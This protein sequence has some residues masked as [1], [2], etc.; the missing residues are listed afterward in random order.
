M[1]GMM[2]LQ[3]FLKFLG[4]N[5]LQFMKGK[6]RQF[7]GTTVGT[8]FKAEKCDITKQTY[9]TV[10]GPGLKTKSGDSLEG[11]LWLVNSAVQLGDV[12]R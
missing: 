8:V 10:G 9:I 6:G 7:C 1:K 11:T 4:I 3:Q 5:E 12:A 2:T